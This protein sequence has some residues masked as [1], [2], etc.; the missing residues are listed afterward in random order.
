MERLFIISQEKYG[1]CQVYQDDSG[2]ISGIYTD[3][4]TAKN[5]L[6]NIYNEMPEHDYIFYEYKIT[7]YQLDGSEYKMTKKIYT[8]TFDIFLEFN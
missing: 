5:A 7:V 2:F 3:L 8:Y 1:D 4:E 6:K